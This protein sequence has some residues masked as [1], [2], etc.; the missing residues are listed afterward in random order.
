VCVQHFRRTRFSTETRLQTLKS[1]GK[2]RPSAVVGSFGE[3]QG[4]P[5]LLQGHGNPVYPP[6]NSF[7]SVSN[8]SGNLFTSWSREKDPLCLY[9]PSCTRTL[10]RGGTSNTMAPLLLHRQN[11]PSSTA[12]CPNFHHF[13]PNSPQC[14]PQHHPQQLVNTSSTNLQRWRGKASTV[15]QLSQTA[16]FGVEVC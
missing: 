3:G 11:F 7:D 4:L 15:P 14:H 9:P 12:K 13:C 5:F 1:K 10:E 6:A 8:T 16:G 2:V